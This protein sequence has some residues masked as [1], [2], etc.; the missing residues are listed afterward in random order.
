[1][2]FFD[3]VFN[4]LTAPITLPSGLVIGVFTGGTSPASVLTDT[5]DAIDDITSY[6]YRVAIDLSREIA[7]SPGQII[8]E[9]ALGG[10]AHKI[11]VEKAKLSAY[12]G[13]ITGD[14]N[15]RELL[16]IP[17]A[18]AIN[19]SANEFRSIA[20][21]IPEAVRAR[22]AP[23]YSAV[24]VEKARYAVGYIGINVPELFNGFNKLFGDENATT[25]DDIIV[26]PREPS[27]NY[28]DLHWWAHE[29]QHV[30][31]YTRWGVNKFA[32]E[33]V[34]NRS[35]VESECEVKAEELF[36]VNHHMVRVG[37]TIMSADQGILVDQF[38]SSPNQQ[39][40]LQMQRD[41]NLVVYRVTTDP[42]TPVWASNTRKSGAVIAIM[43]GDGNFVLYDEQMGRK[44]KGAEW[45]TGT[46]PNP[47]AFLALQNDGNLVIYRGNKA[48]W[49]T[50]PR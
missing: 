15:P 20:K 7:G 49:E 5:I 46:N 26:F 23:H 9:I 6:P 16:T 2:G 19:Q 12:V 36:P 37:A 3:T 32:Y 50:G 11:E 43:Q 34:M 44:G 28:G 22:L 42:W 17:V 40:R 48:I 39:Y 14:S 27:A 25:V 29:L 10:A 33:Y 45:A 41:G 47:G 38:V 31:Q 4:I 35:G 18:A 30:D 13:I 24:V 8:A 21:P 1:M